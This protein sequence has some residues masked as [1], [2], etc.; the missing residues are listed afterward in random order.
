MRSERLLFQRPFAS[1]T[2]VLAHE[3]VD[4]FIALEL[5]TAIADAVL[6]KAALVIVEYAL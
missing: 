3:R 5:L 1:A 6:C 2:R 4:R